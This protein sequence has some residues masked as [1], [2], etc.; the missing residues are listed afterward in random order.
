MLVV[1]LPI[2]LAHIE[3]VSLGEFASRLALSLRIHD[4]LHRVENIL[5]VLRRGKIGQRSI[6]MYCS[7]NLCHLDFFGL[8]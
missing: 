4:G 2:H 5:A 3:T 7:D 1:G 8:L 6:L